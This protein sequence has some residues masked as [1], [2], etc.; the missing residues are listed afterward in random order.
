M[1]IWFDVNRYEL[2]KITCKVIKKTIKKPPF[3]GLLT[4]KYDFIVCFFRSG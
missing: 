1:R 4:E 3:G 2:K